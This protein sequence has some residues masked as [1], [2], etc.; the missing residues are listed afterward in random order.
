MTT[1]LLAKVGGS[2]VAGGS[3]RKVVKE[4]E[5]DVESGGWE[6]LRRLIARAN[7]DRDGELRVVKGMTRR[8]CTTRL[9]SS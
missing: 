1:G 6:G 5:Q 4:E 2:G 7:S 9:R 8:Q 3:R